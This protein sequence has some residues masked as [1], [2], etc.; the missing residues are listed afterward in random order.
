MNHHTDRRVL[1]LHPS[2]RGFGWIFFEGQGPPFDWG[3]A[4]VRENK[5]AEALARIEGL[6]DKYRPHVIAVEAFEGEFTHRGPR[7]R[8]LYRSLIQRAARKKVAVQIYSRAQIRAAFADKGAR[9]REEIA[10]A[11][12]HRVEPLRPRLPKPRKIWVGEHPSIALFCAAACALACYATGE[13]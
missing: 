6:I 12:A 5:N 10:A 7:V 13:A 9:T 11:V 1:G 4:D 2:S 3:T 8:K